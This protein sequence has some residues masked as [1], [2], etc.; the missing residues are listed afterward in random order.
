MKDFFKGMVSRLIE[1]KLGMVILILQLLASVGL[2]VMVE[3]LHMLSPLYISV[4]AGV[5]VILMLLMIIANGAKGSVHIAG[6]VV[7]VVF[8]C[9]FVFAGT[10]VYETRSTLGNM[11]GNKA[12][13]ENISI[14]V[15]KENPAETINEV[16][17]GTF[18]IFDVSEGSKVLETVSTVNTNVGSIITTKEY[19][20]AAS[21]AAALF[22]KEV[23][24]IIM[25]E[26][27][28]SIIEETKEYK[29]F[30]TKTK[31]LESYEH[32]SELKSTAVSNVTKTPFTVFISGID[33]YGNV[34][35]KSRSDVN[36]TATVNPETKQILLVSTPRDYYVETTVSNGM[37]DKLTHAG[38]Y[39]VECSMGTLEKLYDTEINYYVRVNF[40][41]F[42]DI[43][44]ALGGVTVYSD[45]TF[46]SEQGPAFVE[47]D[48]DMN[49]EE[50]LAFVRERHAFAAGDIQRNKD[51]QHLVKGIIDKVSSPAILTKFNKILESIQKNMTTNFEY[52]DI[53]AFV[54]M[55]LDDAAQWDVIMIGVDGEG[56]KRTTYSS[57][58]Y[59]S[60]VMYPDEVQV[61][62][63]TKLI[64]HV[65]EGK[66]FTQEEANAVLKMKTLYD[67]TSPIAVT[68][69]PSATDSK[70][71]SN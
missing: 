54:Q 52:N 56:K 31:V 10:Y 9:L 65:V 40:S 20:D 26:S 39:G 36:M 8:I 42:K 32:K 48:N 53:A 23:D 17:E 64:D 58:K 12:Q 62:N 33:T 60:Y 13:S 11:T 22:N 25:D 49:G 70:S 50:A 29:E 61:A 14:Y 19:V 46:T 66:K 59:Q 43:V 69:T 7:S 34:N 28:V 16:A 57:Q 51:Q 24:A 30:E 71:S 15:L 55:Q 3:R 5:L 47:G 1:R 37:L 38:L 21:V 44:D 45:Y 2:V 6:K 41:G 27:Y 35:K 18:G 67:G 4:L 63:A 68:P